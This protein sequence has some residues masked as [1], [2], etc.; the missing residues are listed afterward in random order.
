MWPSRLIRQRTRTAW[1]V[2][3]G[4]PCWPPI[5]TGPRRRRQRNPTICRTTLFGVSFGLERGRLGRS[6]MQAGHCVLNLPS[7]RNRNHVHLRRHRRRPAVL[8]DQL[9]QQQTGFRSEGSVSVEHEGLLVREAVPRQLHSTT[10]G[11]RLASN[12]GLFHTTTSLAITPS[13]ATCRSPP[14][15]RRMSGPL[16]VKLEPRWQ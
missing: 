2:D 13:R 3:A 16:S 10:G 8:D 11:L 1:T 7:G 4:L 5:W 6:C 9:G 15:S 12:S 14:R